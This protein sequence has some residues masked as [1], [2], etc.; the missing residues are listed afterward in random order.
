MVEPSPVESH[1]SHSTEATEIDEEA[2]NHQE[3]VQDEVKS[4]DIEIISPA[5]SHESISSVYRAWEHGPLL[6]VANASKPSLS[7]GRIDTS[8]ANRLRSDSNDD[9]PPSV[10][11]APV[12]FRQF[13]GESLDAQK[14]KSFLRPQDNKRSPPQSSSQVRNR[15]VSAPSD[16]SAASEATVVSPQTPEETSS[17]E[18]KVGPPSDMEQSHILTLVMQ[19]QDSKEFTTPLNTQV[20]PI[21][22][23]AGSTPRA[24]TK[25]EAE[26]ERKR[27]RHS[28]KSNASNA[29]VH[30]SKP[31]LLLFIMPRKMSIANVC[32]FFGCSYRRL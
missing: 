14:Q 31:S 3:D 27:R 1:N 8:F 7:L 2:Q 29:S 22:H 5:V 10:I 12:G 9:A 13:V 4:P 18:D 28:T 17:T 25:E 24:S 6:A 26:E 32:N 20:P 23:G 30:D 21:R 19:Q 11:H 15:S 16:K